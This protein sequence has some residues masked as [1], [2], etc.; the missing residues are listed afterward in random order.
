MNSKTEERIKALEV[1]LGNELREKEFYLKHKE[2][3]MNPLGKLMFASIAS[4][5]TEHYQRIQELHQRLNEEGKWP[6]T[7]PLIVKG[8]EVK[9]VMQKIVDLVDTSS[10]ADIDDM[11]AVEIAIEFE[12]KGEL[13]YQDLAA[14]VDNPLEKKFYQLLASMEREHRLSLQDA[15][16]YFKDPEGWLR[17]KERHHIDGA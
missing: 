16:E 5:E 8:T 10:R 4:D 3:T 9:S 11:K 1:A 13:F 6:E 17:I 14:K 15:F 12:E 7:I 2:R